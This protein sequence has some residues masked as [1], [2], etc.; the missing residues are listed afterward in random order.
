MVHIPIGARRLNCASL[1]GNSPTAAEQKAALRS[2]R[3]SLLRRSWSSIKF[4]EHGHN[5]GPHKNI[6]GDAKGD[7][8][9]HTPFVNR[10]ASETEIPSLKLNA[11]E[12]QICEMHFWQEIFSAVTMLPVSMLAL[13]WVLTLTPEIEFPQ[14]IWAM[15]IAI[16]AHCPVS[17]TYHITNGLNAGKSYDPFT[18]AF[19]LADI[20]A[21]HGCCVAFGWAVSH[22]DCFFTEA[23]A[24]LNLVCMVRLLWDFLMGKRGSQ[25]D[26]YRV[27]CC[28]AVYLFPMLWRGDFVNYLGAFVCIG[29]GGC[30]QL[31]DETLNGWGHGLFHVMLTPYLFFLLRSAAANF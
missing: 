21:I 29:L 6:L 27:C 20:L 3:R 18:S 25:Q 19:R 15:A 12:P 24:V 23:A 2:P 14:S 11:S 16:W 22:G 26:L 1:W 8:Q 31:V 5:P 7:S 9:I 28:I 10:K 30:F 17:M 4:D 13:W